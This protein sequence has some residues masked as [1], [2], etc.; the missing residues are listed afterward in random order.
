MFCFLRVWK[1]FRSIFSSGRVILEAG[2]KYTGKIQYYEPS[3]SVQTDTLRSLF[4]TIR[5]IKVS[6]ASPDVMG[7]L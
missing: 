4:R 1:S 5:Y 7:V 2:R 6:L 3:G